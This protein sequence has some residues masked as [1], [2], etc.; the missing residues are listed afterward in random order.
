MK[1]TL[2]SA[3]FATAFLASAAAQ[4]AIVTQWQVG[5]SAVFDTTSVIWDESNGT[6]GAR[7]VTTSSLS[8]GTASGGAGISGLAIGSSPISTVVNTNLGPTN[9]ISVT[10]TNFP[11]TGVTLDSVDLDSTL[12]LQALNPLTGTPSPNLTLTFKIDFEETSNGA[13][14]CADGGANG[15]GIN[16]SGCADIFVIDQSSLNFPFWYD[17]TTN[18]FGKAG[19]GFQQ[20]FISFFEASNALKPLSPAAC[21]A[22]GVAS[23]CLG[24]LT[25]EN[26]QTTAQFAAK[27]TTTPITIPEPGTLG[28]LGIAL[29]GLAISRRRRKI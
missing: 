8:W 29:T 12:T 13:A 17:I 9:N 25:A 2:L 14:P 7:N 15:V 5:V 20:Y 22:A 4:S 3:A 26:T 10:H 11:I 18:Q 16:V 21:T 6:G 23:P 19:S 28:L 27:I 1:K 24:F